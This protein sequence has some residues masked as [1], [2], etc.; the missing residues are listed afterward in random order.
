LFANSR[1]GYSFFLKDY[2]EWILQLAFCL[3]P[4]QEHNVPYTSSSSPSN[5]DTRQKA[6][7][8]ASCHDFQRCD[9]HEHFDKCSGSSVLGSEY[10]KAQRHGKLMYPCSPES[11]F[12]SKKDGAIPTKDIVCCPSQ[13]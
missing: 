5:S 8:N 4:R 7:T 9:E 10:D 12:G 1:Q 6:E 2:S 11:S 13:G 3:E